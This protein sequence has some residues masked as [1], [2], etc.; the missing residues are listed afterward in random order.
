VE[1]HTITQ[2]KG[3]DGRFMD[4]AF[5]VRGVELLEERAR[6]E[7]P[8]KTVYFDTNA[9]VDV[10]EDRK[11]GRFATVEDLARRELIRPVASDALLK[12]VVEGS[13]KPNFDLGIKRFFSLDSR[14]MLGGAGLRQRDL[15]LHFYPD[16]QTDRIEFTT[17]QKALPRFFEP[18]EI[19]VAIPDLRVPTPHALRQVFT[20]EL[21]KLESEKYD[22][23]L[24]WLQ[25]TLYDR[26]QKESKENLFIW[27]AK[28]VLRGQ[29]RAA[30]MAAEAYA[31]L[32]IAP[33]FR[34]AFE[35]DCYAAKPR[36][37]KRVKSEFLDR[38]HATIIPFVD[39]FV[40]GDDALLKALARFDQEVRLPAGKSPYMAKVCGDWPTFEER[41]SR[42]PAA[43]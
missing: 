8:V 25:N 17:W 28:R 19:L 18:P 31:D 37:T 30:E 12:E 4:E 43:A 11:P 32:D 27:L 15:L 20:P 22:D 2:A 42:A 39:L 1:A 34:I 21:L 7:W 38:L 23:Y 36:V 40:T 24:H 26:L 14:W 6:K 10:F 16:L 33:A 41:A 35:L 9:F 13:Q 3:C 5:E 29:P